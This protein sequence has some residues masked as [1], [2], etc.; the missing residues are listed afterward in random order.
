MLKISYAQ[1]FGKPYSKLK[2]KE[3]R[4]RDVAV[5]HGGNPTVCVDQSVN[6]CMLQRS[7]DKYNFKLDG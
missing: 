3:S 1:L 5:R 6:C 2:L 7:L 4:Q